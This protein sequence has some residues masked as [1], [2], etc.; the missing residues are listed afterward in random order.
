MLGHCAIIDCTEEGEFFFFL[1]RSCVVEL[2]HSAI[3]SVCY[4]VCPLFR[5]LCYLGILQLDSFAL[6]LRALMWLRVIVVICSCS[7]SD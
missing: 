3:T 6:W 2:S 4:E 5:L 7:D 1:V